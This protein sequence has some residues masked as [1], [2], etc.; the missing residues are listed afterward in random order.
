MRPAI[1][2]HYLLGVLTIIVLFNYVDR[3]ALGVVLQ[4]IKTE[5]DLSD[6]QL[7]VLSGI[8]FAFFYSIMGVPIARWADRGNRVAII[9]L[10]AVVWSAAVVL[11][12]ASAS[13][14]QLLL[15]RVA[16]ATGEAGCVP[17]ALSL[18][19]D[20]FTRAERPRATAIYGLS[21]TLSAV[22]GYMLAG[23]LN[24]L[25]GWRVMFMV[26]GLPGIVLAAIA[27]TTLK[28]PRRV[29]S[30]ESSPALSRAPPAAAPSL[31]EVA[32]TLWSNVTFRHLLLC[33]AVQTFFMYGIGMWHTPFFIRSHGLGTGEIGTWLTVVWGVGGLLG[34]YLGGELACRYAVHN[35]RLQLK[36]LGIAMTASGVLTIFVYLAPNPTIA[37]TLM[38][39]AAIGLTAVNGPLFSTIQTLVPER[40][41]AVSFALVY[42]VANLVGGGL[43]PL[44]AGALSDEFRPWAGEQ[45]L[46][47]A[48]LVLAPG[49][50]WAAFHAWRASR[51]VAGDLRL[52]TV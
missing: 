15:I 39:F 45:S 25:Y 36:S 47:Y 33:F 26:L 46:R 19:A 4:D 35:E 51:S 42:L 34:A 44:V 3:L 18:L 10:T 13:Y 24:E 22:V 29:K 21:G 23:W 50:F 11:S 37:F 7:G 27:W 20:Y 32:A 43:G 41:R 8:A 49:Y 5:F 6:T 31:I 9:S 38:G 2:K 17:P 40:M 48:L 16:V 52:V 14:A 12:G 30:Q 28:E 1:Y